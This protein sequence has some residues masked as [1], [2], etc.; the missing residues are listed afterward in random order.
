M[1][2]KDITKTEIWVSTGRE[3]DRGLTTVMLATHHRDGTVDEQAFKSDPKRL[4]TLASG[5]L[6][7]GNVEQEMADEVV[8]AKKFAHR[9]LGPLQWKLPVEDDSEGEGAWVI[10][11]A[12]P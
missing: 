10:C 12:T 9:H 1:K 2:K 6:V 7:V 5:M 3:K 4:P 8:A 11:E